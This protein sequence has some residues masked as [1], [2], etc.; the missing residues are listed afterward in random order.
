[1]PLLVEQG[2]S[3]LLCEYFSINVVNFLNSR[4][5]TGLNDKQYK[6]K[7]VHFTYHTRPNRCKECIYYVIKKLCPDVNDAESYWNRQQF[8]IDIYIT[9]LKTG[10]CCK[11]KKT[12]YG[13]WS[14]RAKHRQNATPVLRLIPD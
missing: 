13:L 3:N 5:M 6:N 4:S 10:K 14:N 12:E 1:M 7:F 2:R 11:F 8:E 9:D